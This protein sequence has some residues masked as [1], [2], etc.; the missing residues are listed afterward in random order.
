LTIGR[1]TG[2]PEISPAE[3][4]MLA[5]VPIITP[6][7]GALATVDPPDDPPITLNVVHG[8]HALYSILDKENRE[9]EEKK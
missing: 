8:C 6:W 1:N 3:S 9:F 4:F 5:W 2:A 7:V